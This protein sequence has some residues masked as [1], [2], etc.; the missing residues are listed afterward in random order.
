[1]VKR[2]QDTSTADMDVIFVRDIQL[3]TL[4]GAYEFERRQPRTL[5]VNIEIGRWSLTACKT[6]RLADTIDYAA[7]VEVVR[8]S[9]ASHQFHLLEPLAELIA[10][11]LLEKFDAQWARIELSKSGVVPSARDVGVRLERRRG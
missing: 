6:D 3:D 7:V 10:G 8:D 1:M 9:F 5:K 11:C 2:P 4:I